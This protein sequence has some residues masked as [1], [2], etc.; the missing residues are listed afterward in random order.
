M[1]DED[2]NVPVVKVWVMNQ[3]GVLHRVEDCGQ[4]RRS[5]QTIDAQIILHADDGMGHDDISFGW[6]G[7]N[8]RKLCHSRTCWPS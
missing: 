7:Q 4:Y 5:S 8:I 6:D 3:T 2:Y 1:N